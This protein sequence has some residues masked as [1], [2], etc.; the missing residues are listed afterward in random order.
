MGVV[1][2]EG[3]SCSFVPTMLRDLD[4]TCVTFVNQTTGKGMRDA[5][6]V[7][8]PSPCDQAFCSEHIHTLSMA[9]TQPRSDQWHKA[10]A[11]RWVGDPRSPEEVGTGQDWADRTVAP[12][13][14]C[15][16]E[17]SAPIHSVQG[18]LGRGCLVLCLPT[19]YLQDLCFC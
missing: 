2:Q 4:H 16:P 5:G 3:N 19:P 7:G 9:W 15:L 1:E 13:Q 11:R 12:H 8:V 14:C 6:M 10:I 18:S 17:H